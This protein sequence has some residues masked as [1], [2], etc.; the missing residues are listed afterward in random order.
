MN[1]LAECCDKYGLLY[2]MHILI[3]L[4]LSKAQRLN[5]DVRNKSVLLVYLY[6]YSSSIIKI[7]VIVICC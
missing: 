6:A 7:P 5:H 2:I 1:A 3:K 4:L